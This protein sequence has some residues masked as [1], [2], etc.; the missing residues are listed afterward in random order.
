MLNLEKIYLLTGNSKNRETSLALEMYFAQLMERSPA[1][2]TM[3]LSG[4]AL[5][6]GPSFEIIIAGDGNNRDTPGIMDALRKEYLPNCVFVL[7]LDNKILNELIENLKDKNML[8][9]Q[10]TLHVCG[11]GKCYPPIN[12]LKEFFD[13]VKKN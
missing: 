3:F 4:F 11:D 2:F 8:N 5:K 7:K 13:I 6:L 10:V 1:A 9:N 12:S